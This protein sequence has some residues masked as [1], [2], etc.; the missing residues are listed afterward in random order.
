T[1]FVPNGLKLEA[2]KR[3]LAYFQRPE[4]TI[5]VNLCAV[6]ILREHGRS[7]LAVGVTGA[8][9]EFAA[10]D[11]INIAGPD[12]T[13]FARGKTGFGSEEIPTLAEKQGD[14][15]RSLYPQRKRLEVVHRNDLVLL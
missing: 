8:A 5:S 11:I 6:P 1:F 3:W 7:L 12:G 10:G 9:G 13:I 2:K 15:M 4:G 14:E